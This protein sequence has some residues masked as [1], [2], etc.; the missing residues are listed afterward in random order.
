MER[1]LAL[2]R[3][4]HPTVTISETA[5]DM[6]PFATTSFNIETPNMER[7]RAASGNLP[8]LGIGHAQLL[9]VEDGFAYVAVFQTK[10]IQMDTDHMRATGEVKI[11]PLN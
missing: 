9:R 10:A 2:W 4:V 3:E 1:A 6:E 7:L 8:L 11:L 5:P